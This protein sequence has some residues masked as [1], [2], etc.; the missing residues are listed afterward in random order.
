MSSERTERHGRVL[1]PCGLLIALAWVL[2]PT[3]ATAKTRNP[4]P[5]SEDEVCLSCH[6]TAG[7]KSARGT[8]ISI[9]ARKHATSAHA[10]LGCQ[11]CHRAIKDFPHPVKVVKVQMK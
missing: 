8:D 3:R 10:I 6:G 9:N 5:R 11:G 2:A 1:I 4:Q 7:M